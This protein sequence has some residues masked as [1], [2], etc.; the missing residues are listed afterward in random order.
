V[1]GRAGRIHVTTDGDG[2]VW[3]GG[4]TTTTVSGSVSF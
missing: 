4:A 3:V 2:T 1:L